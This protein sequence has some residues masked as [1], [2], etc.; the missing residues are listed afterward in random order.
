MVD[1]ESCVVGGNGTIALG[2]VNEI[3]LADGK[4]GLP[5]SCRLMTMGEASAGNDCDAGGEI[6]DDEANE[7]EALVADF[8]AFAD[9]LARPRVTRVVTSGSVIFDSI[10]DSEE[11]G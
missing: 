11:D 1:D 7:A 2:A 4:V 10:A 3:D 8:F 9:C 6:E 5:L